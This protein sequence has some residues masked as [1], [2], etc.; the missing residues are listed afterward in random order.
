MFFF[1]KKK[2]LYYANDYPLGHVY[3]TNRLRKAFH[4]NAHV[5]DHQQIERLVE[6]GHFVA[7]EIEALYTLKKYRSLKKSYYDRD[8]DN[9]EHLNQIIKSLNLNN[10]NNN[11]KEQA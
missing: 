5:N 7:K 3:F 6:R 2:L 4:G 10:N 9:D 1:K 8:A 11:K